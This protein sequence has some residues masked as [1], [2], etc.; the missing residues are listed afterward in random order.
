M[1]NKENFSD[2][3]KIISIEI[4]FIIMNKSTF[5]TETIKGKNNTTTFIHVKKKELSKTQHRTSNKIVSNRRISAFF[6]SSLKT[7]T[8]SIRVLIDIE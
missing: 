4:F 3:I 1:Q 6:P 7:I 8:S 2:A 5:F